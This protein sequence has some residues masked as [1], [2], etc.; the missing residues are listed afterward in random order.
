MYSFPI[1]EYMSLITE[2]IQKLYHI[3]GLEKDYSPNFHFDA[4]VS[5]HFSSPFFSKIFIVSKIVP[6]SEW[7]RNQ[8]FCLVSI[9]D[10]FKREREL[11]LLFKSRHEN[12]EIKVDFSIS[13]KSIDIV[14]FHREHESGM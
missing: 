6:K 12:S 14:V 3:F 9:M 11:C 4:D 1:D 7:S 5:H 2:S 8:V 10:L 13:N